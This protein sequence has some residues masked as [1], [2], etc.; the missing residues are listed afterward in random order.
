MGT[1]N[2]LAVLDVRDGQ[3]E[4]PPGQPEQE[5]RRAERRR[6]A[7]PLD[8]PR[9]TSTGAPLAGRRGPPRGTRRPPA[10][11]P[12]RR[13]SS[14]WA[15]PSRELRGRGV[16][17]RGVGHGRQP[18]ALHRAR[19]A[20]R[21]AGSSGRPASSGAATDR[22]DERAGHAGAARLLERGDEDELVEAEPAVGL[23]DEQPG[24][25]RARRAPPTARRRGGVAA[26]Q[27]PRTTAGVQAPASTSRRPSRSVASV[28]GA[29]RSARPLL[30]GRGRAGARRRCCAAPRWCRRR[31]GR[32][33]RTGS[34]CSTGPRARPRG[35]AGR[36]RSRAAGCRARSRTACSGCDSPIRPRPA[37]SSLTCCRVNSR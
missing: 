6:V 22:L 10:T 33:A 18:A 25:R 13:A 1:P 37:C 11:A 3:V 32:T 23:R 26:G 29:V 31:S 16:G 35:R 2:W 12:G 19:P 15:V 14:R 7:A 9:S 34:P 28:V 30:P 27:A 36:A 20:S 5:G 21:P 24:E 8:A 17:A 4:L